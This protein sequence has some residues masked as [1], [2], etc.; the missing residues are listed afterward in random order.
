V[1]VFVCSVGPYFS[2]STEINEAQAS[3]KVRG[4]STFFKC[5]NLDRFTTV[6]ATNV[7]DTGACFVERLHRYGEWHHEQ[8]RPRRPG[9][10]HAAFESVCA[11]GSDGH[12]HGGGDGHRAVELSVA[13]EWHRDQRGNFVLL[14]NTSDNEFG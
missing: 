3:K 6:R 11:D 5:K 7:C 12:I 10:Y 14:Y 2:S 1:T 4:C 13:E 9:H 8:P